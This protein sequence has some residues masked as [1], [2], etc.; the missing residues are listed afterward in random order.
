MSSSK[1]LPDA[2]KIRALQPGLMAACYPFGWWVGKEKA[3]EALAS[4]L[5]SLNVS[6]QMGPAPA[7]LHYDNDFVLNTC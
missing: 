2:D 1:L 4:K 5:A 7:A 3:R 6:Q